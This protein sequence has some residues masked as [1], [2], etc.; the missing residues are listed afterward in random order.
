MS[1]RTCVC[2]IGPKLF[3]G[4]IF[5]I[6]FF[7]SAQAKSKTFPI[8]GEVRLSGIPIG[9]VRD[10]VVIN[11]SIF[12][13]AENGIFK[14]TGKKQE[15]LDVPSGMDSKGIFSSLAFDGENK[16]YVSK[17]GSGI[18]YYEVNSGEVRTLEEP[19]KAHKNA[20]KMVIRGDLLMTTSVI[21]F[22]AYSLK[23][24]TAIVDINGLHDDLFEEIYTLAKSPSG[25]TYFADNNQ[26]LGYREKT[27]TF[28]IYDLSEIVPKFAFITAMLFR[29]DLIVLGGDSG[30]YIGKSLNSLAYLPFPNSY[31][32]SSVSDIFINSD[33]R[34]LVA[35]GTLMTII[36]GSER[37]LEP[38]EWLSPAFN[39]RAIET[40]MSIAETSD[41]SIVIASSQQGLLSLS[42]LTKLFGYVFHEASF[43]HGA[44]EYSIDSERSAT[45]NNLVVSER[46][47]YEFDDASGYLYPLGDNTSTG[48]LTGNSCIFQITMNKDLSLYSE[49][50]KEKCSENFS[51][52]VQYDKSRYI[53]FS[54]KGSNRFYVIQDGDVVDEFD[55]PGK[56]ASTLPLSSG[57]LAAID[58]FG[59][60][61]LQMS[62]FK[63]KRIETESIGSAIINCMLEYR[64]GI[65]W[66][67]TSGNGMVEI[68]LD[69]NHV[70]P[71]SVQ[72]LKPLRFIR[73]AK[74]VTNGSIWVASNQGLAVVTPENDNV[75]FLVPHDG[76]ADTDFQ[77]GAFHIFND[78]L[79]VVGD[80]F[81]YSV[82]SA[83]V[84]DALTHQSIKPYTAKFLSIHTSGDGKNKIDLAEAGAS[85]T[86]TLSHDH[87]PLSLTIASTSF[88]NRNNQ[89]IEY[90]IPGL[91]D[92]WAESTNAYSTFRLTDLPI[93]HHVIEARVS[94]SRSTAEQPVSQLSVV[95][96]PPFYMTWQAYAVY[97]AIVIL[98][99]FL[100]H[101]YYQRKLR[102]HLNESGEKIHEQQEELASSQR[103]IQHLVE[104][105]QRLFTNISHEIR[106]PLSI[107]MGRIRQL[108]DN[109][110]EEKWQKRMDAVYR[111]AERME[112]LVEQLISV[113]KLDS[114][115]QLPKQTYVV[116]TTVEAIA[117][118]LAPLIEQK[119]L[120]L[121]VKTSGK[122]EALL[123]VD[124]LEQLVSNLL[125]NAIKYTPE[126]GTI[127]ISASVTS[128]EFRLKVTDSGVGIEDRYLSKIFHRFTRLENNQ[129]AKGVGVG[130]AMVDEIVRANEGWVDVK[131]EVGQ[132]SCFTI[133]IPQ[134]DAEQQ[135]SEGNTDIQHEQ[136]NLPDCDSTRLPVVIVEDDREYLSYLFEMLSGQFSCFTARNGKH[137]MDVCQTVKPALIITD[138]RM[139]DMDGMALARFI[140][141]SPCFAD[142]PIIL[143]TAHSDSELIKMR[144]DTQVDCMLPKSVR[145]EE[146]IAHINN[147]I[148]LRQLSRQHYTA[149]EREQTKNNALNEVS[150]HFD[151]ERDQAF[152]TALQSVLEAHFADEQF[153]RADAARALNVS[154]RQLNRKM[155]E[156][157][158]H[159]FAEYLKRFRI[160]K[161]KLLLCEG[162]Q[163]TV[164][165]LDVGFSS[166]SYF[167]NC[168]KT[169]TG[170]TP[171]AY[172]EQTVLAQR[173]V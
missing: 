101:S 6:F 29:K 44:I 114:V 47:V 50:L 122:K 34:I 21:S 167:S 170:L 25:L 137:A 161:A 53:L 118:S 93:G 108:R 133:V 86:I 158:E 173:A 152:Y 85:Q 128:R 63:W 116:K 75:F 15:K 172:Q 100:F 45:G 169:I 144:F 56:I 145:E 32:R 40:I 28:E 89:T 138:Y 19:L 57:G 79:V 39:S 109:P 66:L 102:E 26:L 156:L 115:R 84:L 81:T 140:R 155:S 134:Q 147:L 148:G 83:K 139:K 157:F 127:S 55:A 27:N 119:H 22:A 135:G 41:E 61:H 23:D 129:Y 10:M 72:Q 112:C 80:K 117:K 160:E 162:Q 18:F 5:I 7:H 31:E 96:T 88:V 12:L 69:T 4:A 74:L 142:T 14:I 38:I 20:W 123:L 33:G 168:F 132:G 154:E 153:G 71:V 37:R 110:D 164:T 159:N 146:L 99:A 35:A 52:V 36:D 17:Y 59:Q 68:N 120:T 70:G 106:T 130:L 9:A 87:P 13:A 16:L 149:K 98:A 60:L 95:V 151:S 141:E 90:R 150:P 62:K 166:T 125:G 64:P 113:E 3:F 24:Q 171:K 121:T 43:H 42:P 163:V 8:E 67:C 92:E 1:T 2:K 48:E 82:N 58:Q 91:I 65:L 11:D 97:A 54:D 165:A 30:I 136:R 143:L 124:T 126:H 111:N 94:D 73:D 103:S 78:M 77:Y 51:H 105:K 76:V 131:S 104:N 46:K 107:I 49:K